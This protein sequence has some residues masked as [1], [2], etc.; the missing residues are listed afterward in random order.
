[1]NWLSVHPVTIM[2]HADHGK[3][4]LLDVL[5]VGEAGGIT[6]HIGLIVENGKKITF[7]IHQDTRLIY[8]RVVSVTD[9][10]ILVGQMTVIPDYRSH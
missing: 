6:Q 2:G 5:F 10:T 8:A 3:T 4:T 9:I 1:M 7:L